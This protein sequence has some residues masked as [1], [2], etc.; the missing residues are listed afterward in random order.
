MAA[1]LARGARITGA[2]REELAA[3][4]GRRYAAGESIRSIAEDTGRSFGFVHGLV[5]ESGVGIRSRGGATRGP[6][7]ALARTT[8]ARASK[9]PVAGE[10]A[11]TRARTQAAPVVAPMDRTG[12]TVEAVVEPGRSHESAAEAKP[13]KDKRKVKDK[14]EKSGKKSKDGKPVKAGKNAKGRS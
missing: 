13:S 6:A 8:V 1:G 10:P 5:G 2:Q 12:P 7:A 9:M 4:L 3:Q 11:V 14:A